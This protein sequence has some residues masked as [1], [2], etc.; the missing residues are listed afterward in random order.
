MN[1]HEKRFYV[2]NATEDRL[3]Y[4]KPLTHREAVGFVPFFQKVI[5]HFGIHVT[6]NG[7]RFK[8]EEIVL[9]VIDADSEV[10]RRLVEAET[11]RR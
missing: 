10:A 7:K 9:E 3:F 2:Y 1:E 6:K 5:K 11:Q 8:P 4:L